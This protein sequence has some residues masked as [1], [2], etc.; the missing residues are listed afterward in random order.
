VE[1]A[2]PHGLVGALAVIRMSQGIVPVGRDRV[3]DRLTDEL[4]SPIK[5]GQ[6]APRTAEIAQRS[7]PGG[8]SSVY[9]AILEVGPRP[10]DIVAGYAQLGEQDLRIGVLCPHVP[11]GTI[12]PTAFLEPS[13]AAV[14]Q[15]ADAIKD[16]GR[17]GEGKRAEGGGCKIGTG[18][19]SSSTVSVARC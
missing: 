10:E 2:R 4:G 19:D 5:V 3:V 13:H 14:A 9:D 11:N 1:E 15:I 6:V 12:I 16:E 17:S 7:E 18:I 8:T